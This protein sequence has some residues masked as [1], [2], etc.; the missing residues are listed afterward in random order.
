MGSAGKSIDNGFVRNY[1]DTSQK[2]MKFY[3]AALDNKAMY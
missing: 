3:M 1:R 2:C